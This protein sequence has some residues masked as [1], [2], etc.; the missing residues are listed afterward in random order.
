MLNKEDVFEYYYLAPNG[1]QTK[2]QLNIRIQGTGTPLQF[3]T[4]SIQIRPAVS[5]TS[6]ALNLSYNLQESEVV[7]ATTITVK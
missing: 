3:G 5:A 2:A 4:D 6:A 7:A 1:E